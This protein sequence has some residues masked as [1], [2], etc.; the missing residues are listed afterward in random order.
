FDKI[1]VGLL[2]SLL[3]EIVGPASFANIEKQSEKRKYFDYKLPPLKAL[4]A[5]FFGFLFVGWGWG[6]WKGIYHHPYGAAGYILAS[7]SCIVGVML[8]W[9]GM[10][11]SMTF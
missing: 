3:G 6:W 8:W 11:W 7:I 5:F 2:N 9:R 10:S 4:I 1:G